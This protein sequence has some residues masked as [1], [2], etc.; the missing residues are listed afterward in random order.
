MKRWQKRLNSMIRMNVAE[1]DIDTARREL[2]DATARWNAELDAEDAEDA[3]GSDDDDDDD[4][5]GGV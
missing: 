4:D 5:G 1:T 3:D 2:A